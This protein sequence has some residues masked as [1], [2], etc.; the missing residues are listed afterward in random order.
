MKPYRCPKKHKQFSFFPGS[1]CIPG[2]CSWTTTSFC[3]ADT[4]EIFFAPCLRGKL[5]FAGEHRRREGRLSGEM[6]KVSLCRNTT[7][8]RLIEYYR[9]ILK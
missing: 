9:T 6:L 2:D 7:G 5:L 1:I 4:E 8:C 3:Q